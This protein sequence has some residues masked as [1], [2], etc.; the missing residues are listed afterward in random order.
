MISAC[1]TDADDNK[2]K[3]YDDHMKHAILM[4]KTKISVRL[5]KTSSNGGSKKLE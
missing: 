5:T 3:N 1:H 4:T 2:V